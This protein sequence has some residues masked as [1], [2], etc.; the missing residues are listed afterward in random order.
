MIPIYNPFT[1]RA[2]PANAN[3]TGC[4]IRFRTTSFPP[5]CSIPVAAKASTY[6]PLPNQPGTITGANNYNINLGAKRTQYHGTI[7]VD[8]VATEKDRIYLRYVNQHNYTPQA[9]VYPEPAAS[10]IGPVTR[11]INNLAQTYLASWVRTITPS[12]LERHE[13]Q[14]HAARFATSRHAS[15]NQGLAYEAGAQ[16]LRRRVVSQPRARRVQ[17]AGIEATSSARRPIPT[18]RFWK[19]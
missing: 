15:Y 18:G 1:T 8:H 4:A 16:G 14:R 10:G 9:N 3:R 19:T 17:R 5:T 6:Y 12:L 11:N 13:V 7:R 2:D